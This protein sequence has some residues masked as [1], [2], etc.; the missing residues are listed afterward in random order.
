MAYKF[1]IKCHK[2]IDCFVLLLLLVVVV[3]VLFFGVLKVV[4]V[5]LKNRIK[6]KSSYWNGT[7]Q[8]ST[9]LE[10]I[11]VGES[12]VLMSPTICIW[13]SICNVSWNDVSFTNINALVFV[14]GYLTLRKFFFNHLDSFPLRTRYFIS[15]LI[16]PGLLVFFLFYFLNDICKGC[17]NV[18][19]V[20][21]ISLFLNC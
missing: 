1:E 2:G 18:T 16:L 21:G 5:V 8:I 12:R 19:R 13:G 4:V 10:D 11:S 20:L 9:G 3:L 7:K 6:Q 15:C 17:L 14:S